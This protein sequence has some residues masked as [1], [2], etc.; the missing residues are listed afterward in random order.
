[1]VHTM[2]SVL[3]AIVWV[4]SGLIYFVLDT[5]SFR[6]EQ[7]LPRWTNNLS[8]IDD[9][10]SAATTLA[11]NAEAFRTECGTVCLSLRKK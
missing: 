4:Q 1:M 8:T 11:I 3:G 2:Q 10:V 6:K 9:A 5:L 7:L